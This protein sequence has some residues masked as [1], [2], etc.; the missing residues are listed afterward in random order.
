MPY[1]YGLAVSG[2]SLFVALLGGATPGAGAVG[3][4]DAT[5]GSA[6][7]ANFIQGLTEPVALAVTPV[8]EPSPWSMIALGGVALLGIMY[9]KKRRTT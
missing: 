2:N 4:Y 5:T 9:R 7:N 3:Q 8:P 6:I 1:P